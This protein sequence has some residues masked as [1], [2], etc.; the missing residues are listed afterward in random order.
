M[1]GLPDRSAGALDAAPYTGISARYRAWLIGL[2]GGGILVLAL[3]FRLYR[4]DTFLHW[5][6]G[7][8]MSYGIEGQRVVHGVYTSLFSFTWD[9]APATYAYL[10]AVCQQLFG[11]TLHTG[12]MLSVVVGVL[13]VPLV[14]LCARAFGLSWASSLLAGGLLAV[15]HWQAHF[16]RMVL[17]AVTA[18]FILLLAMFCLVITF[19]RTRLWMFALCG[20][21]CG[22]APYVFISNRIIVVILIAWLG[23]LVVFHRAW[24]RRFWP[25][26]ALFV[27]V[28]TAALA[29]LAL[30]WS[31]N[32]DLFLAPE[33]HVGIMYNIAYWS[34][35]HPG[36]PTTP[37]N[38]LLHQLP[39]ALGMFAIFGGP[40]PPWG[41]TYASAMDPVTGWLL[42]A[43]VGYALYHWRQPLVALL[44]I[45]F[46]AIWVFGVVLTIDA[47]QM[48]HAV[49]LIAAAF[50]LIG[51]LGDAVQAPLSRFAARRETYAACAILLV[52]VSAV[53]NYGEYFSTWGPQLAGS[54]GF[55][56]QYYDA[57]S[58]VARH[59]TPRGTA[60]YA[61]GYPD[62]FFRFL[63]PHAREF[64]GESAV[65]HPASLY[66]IIAG[67]PVSPS[68]IAAHIAGA[69]Q[70]AVH[71]ADGD[72]A[73]TAVIPPRP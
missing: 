49:G 29:P 7:D 61:Q 37:W 40:Y 25:G 36:E 4:L 58:Y 71:D 63:A 38:V 24:V 11:A 42:F 52:L 5:A 1:I 14:V 46:L 20:L 21:V 62:E 72:L 9:S 30:F 48:E 35:Q 68:A 27:G 16:S 31:R 47:P 60:I 70:E 67:T 51:L 69:R 73:F 15:S 17:P 50:L 43:A 18:A 53:L 44:I 13:S 55:A 59:P 65:F 6:F 32:P 3:F 41:G 10:L 45:W 12:R 56:W 2:A 19:R 66:I 28:F 34:S 64:A 23:Y 39:L 57:A 54:N 8:E 33:R 26:I 22:F